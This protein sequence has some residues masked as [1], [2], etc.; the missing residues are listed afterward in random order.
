M[1]AFRPVSGSTRS[2]GKD[3]LHAD[4]LDALL[5]EGLAVGHVSRVAVELHRVG[6][7]VQAHADAAGVAG[8]ALCL[9]QERGGDAAAPMVAPD[10][11]PPEAA[12]PAR[13]RQ[14]AAGP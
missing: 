12:G 7:R 14:Q 5:V 9:G 8:L 2:S 13:R 11:Q 3:L 10:A 6:L 4:V 1:I